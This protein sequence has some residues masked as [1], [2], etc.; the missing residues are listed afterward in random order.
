MNP[1]TDELIQGLAIQWVNDQDARDASIDAL[2]YRL[3]ALV[4]LAMER[5]NNLT[6]AGYEAA[7]QFNEQLW[8]F[9]DPR[10]EAMLAKPW[11][12]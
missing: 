9:V 10:L 6:P 7:V 11:V 2:D 4:L 1:T 5:H 3:A 8:D 12:K